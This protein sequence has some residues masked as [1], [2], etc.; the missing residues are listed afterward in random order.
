MTDQDKYV[1]KVIEENEERAEEH[2]HDGEPKLEREVE[3]FFAPIVDLI[4]GVDGQSAEEDQV[5]RIENDRE[6]RPS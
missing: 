1:E 4:E 2:Q 3:G 6:Q 5:D